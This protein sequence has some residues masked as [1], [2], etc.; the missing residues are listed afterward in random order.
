M[1]KV[2]LSLITGKSGVGAEEPLE[3][4]EREYWD[5]Y[6]RLLS[7]NSKHDIKNKERSLLV[8]ILNADPNVCYFRGDG[9]KFIKS[10][11]D[12]SSSDLSKLKDSLVLK[13]FLVE[14]GRVR[15]EA[16]LTNSIRNF[17]RFVKNSID[18]QESLD[19]TFTYP[20]KIYPNEV[21]G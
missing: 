9:A 1:T 7:I 19:I 12:I 15:G 21:T 5:W 16:F 13:G 17:Q 20:Y 10:Q 14:T 18:K 2:K 6:I 11:L 3:I 4:T 8:E